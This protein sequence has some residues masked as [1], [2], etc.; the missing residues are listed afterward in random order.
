M[1]AWDYLTFFLKIP[2]SL[3]RW[4]FS[5]VGAR[6]YTF[7]AINPAATKKQKTLNLVY[8]SNDQDNPEKA[9]VINLLAR[10]KHKIIKDHLIK[11]HNTIFPLPFMHEVKK[12]RMAQKNTAD[13]QRLDFVL[14]EVDALLAGTSTD[15][16]CKDTVFMPEQLYFKGLEHLDEGL[17]TYFFEQLKTKGID[18]GK[19]AHKV[20]LNFYSLRTPDGSVLDSVEISEEQERTKPIS[21]RKFIVTCLPQQQNFIS[22]I[23]DGRFAAHRVGATVINFNYRG[24][25]RSKGLVWTHANMTN[26]VISQVERLIALGA[27]PSNIGIEGT[28]LGGSTAIIAAAKLRRTHYQGLEFGYDVKLYSERSFRSLSRM[29]SGY[30][31]PD[32]DSTASKWSQFVAVAAAKAFHVFF[33]PLC[34]LCGW[35]VDSGNAWIEIPEED[36]SYSVVRN[37]PGQELVL[38][39]LVHDSW[40]SMASLIDEQGIE[41]ATVAEE[42]SRS[43]F[44]PKKDRPAHDPR[45]NRFA[46]YPHTFPRYELERADESGV[47]MQEQMCENFSRLLGPAG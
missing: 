33:T 40:A 20:D 41:P 38:D 36:K 45:A 42:R 18:Y 43:Y 4:F 24:I 13:I 21:E 22:Y 25:D 10:E 35:L 15:E 34:W 8:L 47:T 6:I 2:F 44:V 16:K 7:I 23:K 26:D 29:V 1:T 9:V 28:S 11:F 14:A 17:R 5:F 31:M 37:L 46:K 39:G 3:P 32:A 19:V 27:N 30:V 12:R